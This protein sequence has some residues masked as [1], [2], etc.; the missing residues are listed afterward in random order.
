MHPAANLARKP[1][2][3]PLAW[4]VSGHGSSVLAY[5][6][7][8]P[9]SDLDPAASNVIRDA[10][11]AALL[12]AAAAGDGRAFESFYS[13]TVRYAMAVVRRITGVALAEDVLA[14]CYFQ[15]WREAS[16]F[17]AGRGSAL[18]WLLT[19]AR[20]RALDRLRQETLRHGGLSGAPAFEADE[21]QACEGPGPEALLES[22]ESNCRLHA[23]LAGLS[24]TERWVLGLAYF[25]DHSH[26]EIATLT[27]L[28]LGTVK[29]HVTRAQ[30]KLRVALQAGPQEQLT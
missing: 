15:A 18:T 24:A 3:T 23:A 6:H 1:D 17:D 9:E 13:A 12:Q 22:V 26:S 10:Q 25:R 2:M 4:T 5:W 29:S 7:G 16:R 20:S 30:Q 27:G 11:M 8:M 21:S 28:P 14:D 19:M